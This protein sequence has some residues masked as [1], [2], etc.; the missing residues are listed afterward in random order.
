MDF[1]TRGQQQKSDARPAAPAGTTA[2]SQFGETP[3]N[4]NGNIAKV[5]VKRSK[6]IMVLGVL[7]AVSLLILSVV[8]ILGIATRSSESSYVNDEQYQAVF[9]DGGQVYF[10]MITELNSGY[11]TLEDIFYLNVSNN[12]VQPDTQNA[13]NQQIS[14]VKLGCELHGPQDL[15]VINTDKVQFWENL[16]SDGKVTEAVT[17]WQQENPDGQDCDTTTTDATAPAVDDTTDQTTEDTTD[18]TTTE[19]TNN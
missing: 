16:K 15:M 13:A 7:L 2:P 12:S 9:L 6:P 5:S 8:T 18:Q 17:T 14:L 4:P 19:D 11:M 1:S 3:K 10:G